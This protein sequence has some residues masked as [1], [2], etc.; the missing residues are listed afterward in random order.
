MCF[1]G[2][3]KSRD[4]MTLEWI[5]YLRN[6]D[7]KGILYRKTTN[8]GMHGCHTDWCVCLTLRPKANPEVMAAGTVLLQCPS[9]LSRDKY[10]QVHTQSPNFLLSQTVL[11]QSSIYSYKKPLDTPCLP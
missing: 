10:N 1:L 11:H 9:Q 5:S 7:W 3:S 8:D 4:F 2:T 6:Q